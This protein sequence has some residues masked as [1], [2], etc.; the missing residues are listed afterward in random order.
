MMIAGELQTG[1]APALWSLIKTV[2]DRHLPF[3]YKV[4]DING[5]CRTVAIAG[6]I[7]ISLKLP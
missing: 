2:E 3:V 6:C 5:H 4:S 1:E 7:A